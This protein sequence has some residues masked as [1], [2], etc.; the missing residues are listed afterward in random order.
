MASAL[1]FMHKKDSPRPKG[2]VGL[3]TIPQAE[4]PCDAVKGNRLRPGGCCSYGPR[5]PAAV[6]HVRDPQEGSWGH[7]A[8]RGRRRSAL[9]FAK[10]ADVAGTLFRGRV[11]TPAVVTVAA[12]LVGG[13]A[14]ARSNGVLADCLTARRLCATAERRRTRK[15]MVIVAAALLVVAAE[16]PGLGCTRST[17]GRLSG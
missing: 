3:A 4:E 2:V 9:R 1:P 13:A 16:D 17:A 11:A 6:V 12:N 10:A 14:R 8:R 7:R 15:K 5:S